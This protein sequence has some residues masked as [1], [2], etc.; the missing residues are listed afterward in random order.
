MNSPLRAVLFLAPV[1]GLA[2]LFFSS[3]RNAPKPAASVEDASASEHVRTPPEPSTVDPVLEP[4]EQAAAASASVASV[5]SAVAATPTADSLAA[6]MH[7][8]E[9]LDPER[10]LEI[11]QRGQ[12]LWPTGPR[13][14]EF[15][16]T[17]VKCLY[18]L[19]RP[20]EGRGAAEAMVNRYPTSNWALEVE[21]QT[22][23]HPHVDH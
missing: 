21:R 23:A 3:S 9:D 15:A 19:D 17:Q 10:A 22:G 7:S 1:L 20:S 18:R 5:A 12:A 14:P 6:E 11:A 13:A 4:P 8:L 2:A 16:A